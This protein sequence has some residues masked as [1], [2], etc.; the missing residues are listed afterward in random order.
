MKTEY[1]QVMN[2][3]HAPE[4]LMK[5]TI[6][7][8]EQEQTKHKRSKKNILIF[9]MATAAAVFLLFFI[10]N[11]SSPKLIYND[12]TLDLIRGEHPIM[13]EETICLKEYETYVGGDLSHL[14]EEKQPIKES[15]I[16]TY[17]G[18]DITSDQATFYYDLNGEKIIIQ[19]SKTKEIADKELLQ[20]KASHLDGMDVIL[21]KEKTTGRLLAAG[22]KKKVQF[23]ISATGLK[24]ERFEEYLKTFL[25]N[26]LQN[27]TKQ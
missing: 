22:E 19:L 18:K 6:H 23:Y 25:K 8:I 14:L 2:Q 27:E 7:K 15:I 9:S 16:V 3:I 10:V 5:S 24:E 11:R 17:T 4:S 1:K 13:K 12:I 20:G 21:G 26:F